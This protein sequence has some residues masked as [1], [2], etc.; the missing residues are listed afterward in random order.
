LL[1]VGST[2]RLFATKAFFFTQTREGEPG[3]ADVK[4]TSGNSGFVTIMPN[5]PGETSDGSLA[6]TPGEAD[7]VADGRTNFTTYRGLAGTVPIEVA[8]YKPGSS[9]GEIALTYLSFAT[10]T[11]TTND[12][13]A[14]GQRIVNYEKHYLPYGLATPRE[15]LIG[16]KGTGG[17]SGLVFGSGAN[18]EGKL[19]DVGG[20]SRFD[21]DFSNARYTG[22]LTLN[23]RTADGQSAEFG[24]FGFANNLV[25]GV[26]V[27]A[28]LDNSAAAALGFIEPVFYGPDGQEVGAT[29]QLGIGTVGD[30][31]TLQITGV[32]VA[33]RQ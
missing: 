2:E 1:N 13:S 11:R 29:F 31:R 26:F 28:S 16:R 20:T 6:Y 3:F 7:R 19:Y 9:N 22:S 24:T 10:W 21:V 12:A 25:D 32:A 17:Y 23:G 27:R 33:K 15:L 14:N 4:A 5:G 30:P 18:R 8:Y